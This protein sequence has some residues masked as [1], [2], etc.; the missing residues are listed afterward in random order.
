MQQR[1]R[2]SKGDFLLD[3]NVWTYVAKKQ[4]SECGY[5]VCNMCFFTM[6]RVRHVL[7]ETSRDFYVLL[8]VNFTCDAL[9]VGSNNFLD[10]FVVELRS[11]L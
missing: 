10:H 3:K 7:L 6:N 8:I 4:H 9:L 11:L 5:Q 2:Q 1:S